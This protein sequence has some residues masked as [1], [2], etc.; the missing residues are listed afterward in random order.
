MQAI[1]ERP[2]GP[3]PIGRMSFQPGSGPPRVPSRPTRRELGPPPA[4]TADRS[5]VRPSNG[6]VGPWRGAVCRLRPLGRSVTSSAPGLRPR[7]RLEFEP[8]RPS[9]PDRLIGWSGGDDQRDT[10]RIDFPSAEAALAWAARH[11]LEVDRVEHRPRTV[12]PRPYA[13]SLRA[14]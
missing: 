1:R 12:R 4:S 5:V 8:V 11:G 13:E 7:W 10:V 6:L 9:L 3:A 14:P 2:V